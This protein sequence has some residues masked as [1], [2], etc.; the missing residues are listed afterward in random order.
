LFLRI[1]ACL[2]L[3]TTV[4]LAM[5]AI[6]VKVAALSNIIGMGI[7]DEVFYFFTLLLLILCFVFV[8]DFGF[9]IEEGGA[10]ILATLAAMAL[11][12]LSVA[13]C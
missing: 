12:G 5:P 3:A 8:L 2:D 1:H 10:M 9:D 7:V 13:D 4:Q 6:I 11:Q